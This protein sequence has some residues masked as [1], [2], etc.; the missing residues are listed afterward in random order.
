MRRATPFLALCAAGLWL[1]CAAEKAPPRNLLLITL[2]TLRAD[3]LGAY[4]YSRPTSPA[5]DAFAAQAT[6]F[7]DATCSMPT[8]LP[9]HVTIFTGLRPSQHG[10]RRNGQAPERDLRT[11]FDLL[12]ERGVATGAVIGSKVLGE[13]YLGGLGFGEVVFPGS[14]R[15]YQARAQHVTDHAAA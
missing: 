2:D 7:E 5:L 10:V 15:Q 1:S 11:V 3:H 9:S 4:G 13:K 12:A 8:T 6:L 14:E